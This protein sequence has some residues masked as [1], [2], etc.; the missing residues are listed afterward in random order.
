[1]VIY[2]LF[3]GVGSNRWVYSGKG[4]PYL[5]SFI[6]ATKTATSIGKNPKPI[7]TDELLFM[8]AA[9]LIGV[10]VFA[11]LI[12][13]MRD[14]IANATKASTEYR[15]LVD[16]TLVYMRRLNLPKEF[17]K[18]VTDWFSFTWEQQRTLD[19]SQLFEN[20]P[21]NLKTDIALAVH[22]QTLSKVQLFAECETA[23]LRELVLKLMSVTYI[24]GDFVCK[25]GDIGKEMYI[26]KTGHLQVDTFSMMF[27]PD[28]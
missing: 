4:H 18:R 27:S 9:W 16:E 26:I 22:I 1:M 20:L 2:F 13:Q 17:Q 10:F 25:K 24:P 21:S 8:T 5:R 19:D 3:I 11:V 14:I 7:D 23:L 6:F 12:G 28:L 15:Q